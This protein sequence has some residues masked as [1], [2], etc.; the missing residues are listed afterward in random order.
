MKIVVSAERRP[1]FVIFD[2]LVLLLL[3]CFQV[4]S[5]ITRAQLRDRDRVNAGADLLQAREKRLDLVLLLRDGRFQVLHFA[6][7]F[8][9]FVEQHRIH[10]VVADSEEFAVLIAHDQVR[11]HRRDFFGDQPEL[12]RIY[13]V[14][15]CNERSQASATESLRWRCV[16]V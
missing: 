12:R 8:E 5:W 2:H 15:S 6:M 1:A 3:V 14:S 7:L 11:V 4:S 13:L 10:C 9:E 16:L